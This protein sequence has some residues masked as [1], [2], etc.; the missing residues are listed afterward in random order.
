MRLARSASSESQSSPYS[1]LSH[2]RPG[3]HGFGAHRRLAALGRW[4]RREVLSSGVLERQVSWDSATIVAIDR[5][6]GAKNTEQYRAAV[7][8]MLAALKDPATRVTS[9]VPPGVVPVGGWKRGRHWEILGSDST[10]VIAIPDFEDWSAAMQSLDS[11]IADV[12]RA[13]SIVFDLRGAEPSEV[14]NS[15]WIFANGVNA[16]LPASS[17]AAPPQRRRMHS[18]FVPQ[19]GTTSGGYWSGIYEQA[20]DVINV[21]TPNRSRRVI[22][23]TYPGSDIPP[24][25]FALRDNGQ[26]AICRQWQHCGTR[27]GA[28]SIVSRR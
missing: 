14:G 17:V 5:V 22:F 1:F 18:G 27:A 24:V 16:L 10:L 25:A 23:L 26:G 12:R 28:T 13:S 7:N 19:Q 20:G 15:G 11:A 6:S 9:K 4:G 21:A 8:D 3:Q 2:S